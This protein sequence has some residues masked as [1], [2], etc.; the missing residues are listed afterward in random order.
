MYV[1]QKQEAVINII[2]TSRYL[3]YDTIKV[4][5][6]FIMDQPFPDGEVVFV[7][8]KKFIPE[9]IVKLT[10]ENGFDFGPKLSSDI[11][12]KIADFAMELL[13]PNRTQ[14]TRQDATLGLLVTYMDNIQLAP[15][16]PNSNFYH[17]SYEFNLYPD[18]EGNY[19]FRTILPLAGLQDAGNIEVQLF[20]VLPQ[21]VTFDPTATK[22]ISLNGQEI[23]ENPITTENGRT[24]LTFYYKQDPTFFVKYRYN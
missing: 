15:I 12:K 1:C 9:H 4:E 24:L 14:E 18:S 8:S 20:I 23:V 7:P 5:T 17:I 21:G 3:G 6:T 13:D 10:N 19:E 11:N 2:P 16:A 22:G